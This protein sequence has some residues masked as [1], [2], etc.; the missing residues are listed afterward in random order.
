LRDPGTDVF[1][2]GSKLGIGPI[3]LLLM[4]NGK[5]VPPSE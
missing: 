4:I 2:L 1:K 5:V 3:E